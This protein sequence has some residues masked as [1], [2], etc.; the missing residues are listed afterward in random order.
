MLSGFIYYV[1]MTS[2]INKYM[3]KNN[4]IYTFTVGFSI[5]LLYD[6]SVS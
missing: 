1:F 2:F 3:G 6:I 4:N 5:M